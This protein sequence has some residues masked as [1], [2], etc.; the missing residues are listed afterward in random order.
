VDIPDVEALATLR[1]MSPV[2]I[3]S[4]ESF[5]GLGAYKAALAADAV[6]VCIVD[7]IWNGVWTAAK[8]AVLAEAYEMHIAPHNAFGD[9]GTLMSAHLAAGIVNNRI[10]EYRY[11]EAPWSHDFLTHPITIENGTLILPDRPGWGSDIDEEALSARPPRA[12]RR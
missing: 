7:P 11:D 8:I 9:L 3:A 4:L 5:Y 6:D 12:L 1:R 2:P 10:L